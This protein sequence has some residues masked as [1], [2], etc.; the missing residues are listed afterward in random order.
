[1]KKVRNFF[2]LVSLCVAA[3]SFTTAQNDITAKE[4]M[5]ANRT[6]F[7][8]VSR[9]AQYSDFTKDYQKNAAWFS[10][11]FSTGNFL[12][13]PKDLL[14]WYD[15]NTDN[16][17]MTTLMEYKD[18][19]AAHHDEL[20]F[21]E[22]KNARVLKTELKGDRINYQ[23]EVTKVE[24]VKKTKVT[25]SCKVILYITYMTRDHDA[26]ITG[27][28]WSEK[29]S[30]FQPHLMAK[31]EVR[32]TKSKGIPQ[33]I[34]TKDG[35]TLSS[36]P[37]VINKDDYVPGSSFDVPVMYLDSTVENRERIYFVKSKR[38]SIGVAADFMM[39][40]MNME[41]NIQED[42]GAAE[43]DD[44]KAS[45]Y[46]WHVGV[47]YYRQLLM[48]SK[49]R[50]GLDV[51]LM[52]G[53]SSMK[54]RCDYNDNYMATDADDAMYSRYVFIRNY[55]ER[56][57]NFSITLPVAIRYD[58]FLGKKVSLALS[59]GAKGQLLLPSKTR[60]TFDGLYAGLYEDM[61]NIYMDQNGYYDYGTYEC[62]ITDKGNACKK[63]AAS[64]FGTIGLQ[65]FFNP[66]WSLDVNVMYDYLLTDALEQK[67]GIHLSSDYSQFQSFTYFMRNLPKHSVGLNLRLKY[68]F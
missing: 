63:F 68:N 39:G 46:N 27:I 23:V 36:K 33:T 21:Y 34:K 40:F 41:K 2:L 43:F 54:F 57:G 14:Q 15:Y 10:Y 37:V 29:G 28:A 22:V 1:M 60:A 20:S 16:K 49:N 11:L 7:D 4:V 12:D 24:T 59:V 3:T 31:Y 47:N 61:F 19:A 44:V 64:L 32:D 6:V 18:F 30:Y 35:V 62:D 52:L 58:R 53:K 65:F 38:N 26:K 25:D 8:L 5:Q 67:E 42:L 9:Y 13:M 17:D 50:L 56:S 45:A 66:T 51:S 55:Q 48:A